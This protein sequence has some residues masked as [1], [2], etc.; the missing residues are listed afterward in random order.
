MTA[1]DDTRPKPRKNPD[2]DGHGDAER[3]LLDAYGSGRL[4]HAWLLTGPEGI[5]KATLAYRFARWV[6]AGGGS[7]L[8]AGDADSLFVAP[9]HPVFRRVAA[10]GHADM[11][12]V[13]RAYDDK[14]ERY[15]TEIVVDDVRSVGAFLRLTAAEGG[16]RVVVVDSADE[17]N[18]HAANAI[19]KVL[20]EPPA[21]ALLLLVS[22]NPGRLLPT[23]RS[24]CRRLALGPLDD[25]T[26]AALVARYRPGT[27][28]ADAAGLARL[29]DG[30]IGHA[31]ALDDDGGLEFHGE[32]DGLM[33]GLP[34]L[35][36][37]RAHALA[38]R[39]G[40]RDADRLF[41]VAAEM[42]TGWLEHQIL[43]AAGAPGADGEAERFQTLAAG[44]GLDRWLEVWEKITPLLARAD[45]ANMD[46][47][48]VFL[49]A[50]LLVAA[51]ARP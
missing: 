3:A 40:R 32:L 24:R 10:G 45:G 31:L 37:A 15:R 43:A 2:L 6:L 12:T 42:L 22:H 4:A 21:Q 14:R 20:E 25:A 30:S 44:P 27:T 7:D 50:L 9:D 33:M 16:W 29:A 41:P 47:K 34:R 46:R 28:A 8:F 48:Q 51:A 18:V 36:A 11:L 38:A 19:L 1:D 39:V 17:M 49:D 26:V 35:D 13:E 5:G 23:I